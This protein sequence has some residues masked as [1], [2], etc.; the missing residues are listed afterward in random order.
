MLHSLRSTG[1]H[2]P[3]ILKPSLLALLTSLTITLLL[4]AH[5]QTMLLSTSNSDYQIT[6]IFSE[7]SIFNIEIEIDAPLA[8]GVY[9]NPDIIEITYQVRGDLE[10]GT[11][12]GFTSFNLQRTIS[13]EDF[14]SQGS[15]LSFEIADTAVLSD[16]VQVAELAGNGVVF[17]FNG[18]EI[19]NG[20]FH[21]ALLELNSDGSGR[22]QNS[23]NIPS[24]DPFQQINFGEEYITDLIF[25]PGNTTLITETDDTPAASAGG[26]GGGCF[27]ATAAYGGYFESEVMVLRQF[28]DTQLLSNHYGRDLVSFYYRVSPPIADFI[29]DHDSLRALTR[30]ALMPVVYI[31]QYPLASSLLALL[32]ALSLIFYFGRRSNHGT[33]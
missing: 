2:L 20:R 17:T 26:D 23:N 3:K 14:Y 29:A 30:T 11:P 8:S 32:M 19:D 28:R 24:A 15:S 27:I 1:R 4:P 9:I 16:G 33:V 18:R 10:A 25:D 21:P 12:S 7:V 31:I 5:A 13:G 6:N 22:I